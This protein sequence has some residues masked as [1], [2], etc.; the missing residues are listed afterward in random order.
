M[1]LGTGI[2]LIDIRRIQDS[3][4]RFGQ[5][6]INRV[7]C[8]GEIAFCT[9]RPDPAAAFARHYAV[10]EAACKALG[11]GMRQ[12][13]AWRGIELRR[14]P[15]RKPYLCFHGGALARLEA[16]MPAGYVP[17]LHVSISDEPPYA[18]SIVI[19]ECRSK[20]VFP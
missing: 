11:T 13:V 14:E 4:D 2:D 10:K 7:F 17:V 8:P 15:G 16:L 6:F 19:I 12:G 1:I 9:A 3:L 20:N 18:T 5:R